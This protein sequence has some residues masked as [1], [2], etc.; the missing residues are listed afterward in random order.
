PLLEGYSPVLGTLKAPMGALTV[1]RRRGLA[2]GEDQVGEALALPGL[3]AEEDVVGFGPAVEEVG[4]G[5]PGEADAAVDLDVLGGHEHGGL[6][7]VALGH[8]C[9]RLAGGVVDV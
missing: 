4:V 1:T 6:T 5:V 2:V 9:G 7:R 8:G 3:V